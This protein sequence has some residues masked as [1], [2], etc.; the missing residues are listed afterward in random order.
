MIACATLDIAMGRKTEVPQ[1][2][3]RGRPPEHG[4]LSN[5]EHQMLW[6]RRQKDEVVHLRRIVASITST[7]PEVRQTLIAAGHGEVIDRAEATFLLRKKT[8]MLSC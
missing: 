8:C 6:R 4:S 3:P 2:A 5:A 1:T 7:M